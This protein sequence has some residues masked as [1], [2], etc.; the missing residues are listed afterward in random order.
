MEE[1]RCVLEETREEPDPKFKLIE[2][3]V[4][5]EPPPD[6]KLKIIE[7]PVGEEPLP[8]PKLKI[9]E[10]PVG[11][12]E[13][14]DPKLK[15]IERPV[16]EE[17]KEHEEY[18]DE[19][20][21]GGGG[22][23]EE[24]GT[25][26]D[27][28]YWDED[29]EPCLPYIGRMDPPVSLC[30]AGAGYTTEGVEKVVD[31]ASARYDEV[32]G[33]WCEMYNNNRTPL[34]EMPLYVLPK[35]TTFCTPGYECYHLRY[36]TE[37]ISETAPTH[38]YFRPSMMMQV[39]SLRLSSPLAHPVKIYGHFSVR[40]CWEPLRNYLFKRSRD[41][42][43]TVA[44]GC[45]FMPLCSPCRGIYVLQHILLDIDLWIK[46]EGNGS[47]DQPLFCGYVELDTSAAQFDSKLVRRL[48]GDC[49]SLDMHFAFPSDGIETA[50]E[51]IAEAQHP[52]DVKIS[53]LTSGFDDDD[54]EIALYD[55]TFCGRGQI[56]KHFIAVNKLEELHVFS[57]LDGSVY[58]WTFRAGVGVIAAPDRPVSS[59]AQY[60]VM[61]V[62]FRTRGKAASAWQWSCIRNNIRVAKTCS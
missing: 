60:F 14:P 28:E 39:F 29:G 3:P 33:E 37:V 12:K 11:E 58:K 51:I 46:E 19:E 26:G 43:A 15:I 9:I 62:S 17:K 32:L 40:D 16:E 38:P 56:I 47:G 25:D 24:E 31:A 21:Y 30:M 34:P 55:G 8:D 22:D 41:H 35:V 59:F 36:W 1:I 13:P 18:G 44:P 5:E 48:Q 7:R 57:K 54:D 20:E 45:S 10:R 4:V 6:P 61:N 2:H 52:S 50:I 53:A 42:P 27:P 23:T 49:H